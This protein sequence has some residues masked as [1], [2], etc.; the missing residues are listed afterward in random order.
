MERDPS[1]SAERKA[2]AWQE[3]L[4][5]NGPFKQRLKLLDEWLVSTAEINMQGCAIAPVLTAAT[6]FIAWI[7]LL[8]LRIVMKAAFA[9]IV[10]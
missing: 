1:S 6:Q 4:Q 7:A 10:M 8:Q 3:V 5:P 2:Q 9:G